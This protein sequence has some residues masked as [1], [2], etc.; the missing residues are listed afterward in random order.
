MLVASDDARV[1]LVL[2]LMLRPSQ[3]AASLVE[4]LLDKYAVNLEYGTLLGLYREV[5]GYGMMIRTEHS[6]ASSPQ[7]R[8]SSTVEVQGPI[9]VACRED[10]FRQLVAS[11]EAERPRQS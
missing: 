10:R 9:L 1:L 3:E 2:L 11:I 4:S 5:C 6:C 7:D 8:Q